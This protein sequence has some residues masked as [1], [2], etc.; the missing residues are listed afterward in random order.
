LSR[1]FK[2]HVTGGGC[3]K[4]AMEKLTSTL[5]SA[6]IPTCLGTSRRERRTF[7]TA[8]FLLLSGHLQSRSISVTTIAGSRARGLWKRFA[9]TRTLRRMGTPF[10]VTGK[11][12]FASHASARAE[13]QQP[14]Q[15]LDQAP[16]A[17]PGPLASRPM[18]QPQQGAPGELPQRPILCGDPRLRFASASRSAW[19]AS[20]EP[21]LSPSLRFLPPPES[22]EKRDSS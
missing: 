11:R 12:S 20:G 6:E 9:A 15:E 5:Y 16:A 13:F 22:A 2:R 4:T 3:S 1:R 14:G 18:A 17:Q 19:S 21:G 7:R 8:F 10:S